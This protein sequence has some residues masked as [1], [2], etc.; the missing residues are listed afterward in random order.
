M[1]IYISMYT[2]NTR[3]HRQRKPVMIDDND[4]DDEADDDVDDD[5]DDDDADDE[6]H[7]DGD[8]DV[9]DDDDDEDYN[10]VADAATI[11]AVEIGCLCIYVQVCRSYC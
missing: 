7:D 10:V 3:I 9:D 2:Q 8:D 11:V 1:H 5:E 4:D 6:D